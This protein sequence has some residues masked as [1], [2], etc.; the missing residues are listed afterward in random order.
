[1]SWQHQTISARS[2]VHPQPCVAGS[3]SFSHTRV[4]VVD[5]GCLALRGCALYVSLNIQK[6]GGRG[7]GGGGGFGE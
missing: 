7:E 3:L 1:M 4:V 6:G 2:C 5:M